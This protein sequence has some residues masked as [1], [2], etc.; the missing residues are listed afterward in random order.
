MPGFWVCLLIVGFVVAPLAAL[1]QGLPLSTPFT[2]PPTV[3]NFLA[4]NAGLLINEYGI[5]GLL[6]D[7]P[8]PY[9]FI[10]SLW[11]LA[12]A[13]MCYVALAALGLLGV[14]RHRWLV[15]ALAVVLWTLMSVQS[16]C[17]PV[18]LGDNIL[19]ISRCSSSA[20]ARISSPT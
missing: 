3:F 14:L 19:R 4:A 15:L 10:G 13:A 1:L 17:V 5:A 2:N 20:P 16:I 7:N 12:L 8:N 9:V 18:P 11:T 6:A